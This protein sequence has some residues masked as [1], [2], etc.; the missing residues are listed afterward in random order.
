MH[1]VVSK[2]PHRFMLCDEVGLGKTIEAAMVIKELRARKQVSRVLILA[3]SGLQRQWQFEL[4]TKFNERFAIY[5]KNTLRYLEEKGVE[6]PW[7]DHDSIITSHSWASWTPER[8]AEIAAVPWD[9][10]VVDEAHHARAQRHGNSV[11]RTNLYRLVSDLIGQPESAR[12]AVLLL[13]ASPMQ[14]EYHEL[15]SLSEMLDPIL[16]AS[17]EDFVEHVTSPRRTQPTGRA[18]EQDGIPT[19]RTAR[20]GDGRAPR[21]LS[22]MRTPTRPSNSC[23][24]QSAHGGRRTA[25]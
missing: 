10:V 9:M 16:F 25:P 19:R 11:S 21:A 5:T 22:R 7:M 1:R 6:N 17:E 2:Y 8:R 14:L 20:G 23:A 12:R 18:I 13:T 3:P 24:P 15:Y 4:K